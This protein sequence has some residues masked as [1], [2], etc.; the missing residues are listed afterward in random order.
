M[1]RQWSLPDSLYECVR[2]HHEPSKAGEYPLEVAI[3]HLADC[4]AHAV[5]DE[6]EIDQQLAGVDSSSWEQTGLT[7]EDLE[8]VLPVVKSQSGEVRSLLYK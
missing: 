7:L 3:V 1:I 5:Q 8:A 6:T 2:Y 4:I